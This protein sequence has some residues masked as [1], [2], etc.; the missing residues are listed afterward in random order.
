MANEPTESAL[1]PG[2][3]GKNAGVAGAWVPGGWVFVMAAVALSGAGI[4]AAQPP[5]HEPVPNIG[6]GE[7]GTVTSGGS[8]GGPSLFYRGEHIAPPSLHEGVGGQRP[9]T[10]L[11]GSGRQDGIGGKRSPSFR[12]DRITSL[13]SSVGYDSV[14]NPSIAPFKRI[15]ALNGVVL[16]EDGKGT[17]VLAIRSDRL[18]PVPVSRA[19]APDDRPRDSFWGSILLDFQGERQVPFPSVAPESRVLSLD[20][21]PPVELR[22]EKDLAD[23]FYARVMGE[24]PRQPVRAVF[25]MDAPRGYFNMPIPDVPVDVRAAEVPPLPEAVRGEAELFAASLGLSRRD[26]LPHVLEV[27]TRHFRSF[28]ESKDLGTT[29]DSIFLDLAHGMKG[30][31]RHRAYGFV[32]TAQALGLPARFVMNE[33]HAW[34]EVRLADAGF[35]RIDLGGS[36]QGLTAR[37]Q[38]GKVFYRASAPDPL[39][40][41]PEYIEA[42]R[43]VAARLAARGQSPG[44]AAGV[45]GARVSGG[46]VLG[47]LRVELDRRDYQ[48]FRG[49]T[50]VLSG[51]I[52]DGRDRGIPNLR[53]EVS[54]DDTVSH[55]LGVTATQ[56]HGYFQ[57][58]VGVPPEQAVGEYRLRVRTPGNDR[59]PPAEAP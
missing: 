44:G 45:A 38:E 32:I 30:V 7:L 23:N 29:S 59:Y 37:G 47:G 18:R 12:P 17:P 16:S 42:Y 1:P 22:I 24:I 51:R 35:L 46:S 8:L 48:V 36:V 11:P 13:E 21:H 19:A 52:V 56:A 57:V 54:L 55:L 28:V 31:C 58:E 39:P 27:L 33:A 4:V 15:S 53:V 5:L 34:V 40:R 2:N 10:P 41:P 49:R 50:L 43:A 9:M 26:S 3:R 14:F 25:L 6:S 20:T